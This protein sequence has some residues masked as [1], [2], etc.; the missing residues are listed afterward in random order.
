M[1]GI[2][3]ILPTGE[4]AIVMCVNTFSGQMIIAAWVVTSDTISYMPFHWLAQEKARQVL[5]DPDYMVH[6]N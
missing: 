2:R 3:G 5:N 4:A 6:F 1:R